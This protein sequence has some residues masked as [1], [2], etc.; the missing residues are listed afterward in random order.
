M[1]ALSTTIAA[2]ALL[3]SIGQ[4][5]AAQAQRALDVASTFP[6]NMVHLGEGAENMARLLE[7]VS[8]GRLKMK[9]HGAGDLVP[10][11]AVRN[12][13]SPGA[14]AAG[15]DWI[16]HWAGTVPATGLLGAIDRKSVVKGKRVS[17]R[18]DLGGRRKLK[19]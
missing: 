8:G 18:V 7:D 2:A 11:F 4:P 1:R 13:V 15:W 17:G 9:V 10:A 16:G 3:W 19:K 5:G 14:V 6:K 12:A